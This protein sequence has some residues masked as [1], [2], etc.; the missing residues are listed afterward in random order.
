M[1]DVKIGSRRAQLNNLD[2]NLKINLS[3]GWEM[4]TG[5]RA[6][7]GKNQQSMA[8]LAMGLRISSRVWMVGLLLMPIA[9]KILYIEGKVRI[10]ISKLFDQLKK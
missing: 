4:L 10:R 7:S 3:K 9:L 2:N 5:I 6:C 1:Q 8:I